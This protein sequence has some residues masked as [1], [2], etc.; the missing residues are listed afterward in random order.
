[1]LLKKLLK[2]PDIGYSFAP[3]GGPP[4]EMQRLTTPAVDK[5]LWLKC[6]GALLGVLFHGI[7]TEEDCPQLQEWIV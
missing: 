5:Q 3:Q 2:L 7:L 1:M 6:E 4:R